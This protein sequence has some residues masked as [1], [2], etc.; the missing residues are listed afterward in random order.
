ME[1]HDHDKDRLDEWLDGAL[2]RYGDAEPRPG[3]EGRILA[4]L[5][6]EKEGMSRAWARS[7]GLAGACAVAAIAIVL[8]SRAPRDQRQI[9]VNGP[10]EQ[11]TVAVAPRSAAQQPAATQALRKPAIRD[12]ILRARTRE[13]KRDTFPSSRALSE[14][15]QLLSRYVKEFPQEAV[16]IAKKQAEEQ[17]K[18]EMLLDG[19][20]SES[21]LDQQ[22]R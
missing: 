18:V 14:Q 15:E 19:K 1:S 3:L 8:L 20:L 16:L 7:L 12:S 2:Q 9:L 17:Q 11:S 13:P 10:A 6:A 4:N 5:A 21:Q 22:E